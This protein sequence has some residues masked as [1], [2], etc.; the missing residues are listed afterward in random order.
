[1]VASFIGVENKISQ[2]GDPSGEG[3][4]FGRMGGSTLS[5]PPLKLL[6]GTEFSRK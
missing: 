1:M 3:I 2:F 4:R 6:S 5:L